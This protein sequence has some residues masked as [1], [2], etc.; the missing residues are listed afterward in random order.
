MEVLQ[1]RAEEPGF[2]EVLLVHLGSADEA[3]A[4][5]SKRWPE[6]RAVSD[7]NQDLYRFFG[8]R[9]GSLSQLFAPRVLYAGWQALRR[10]HGVGKP[11]GNPMR[12]SG[13][14]LVQDQEVTWSHRHEHAGVAPRW[15]ELEA[16]LND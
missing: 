2:P 3:D 8:L 14:F 13:W 12:M 9:N 11:V 7:P 5:F 15:G 6:A 10:G 16:I 1:E 4:F